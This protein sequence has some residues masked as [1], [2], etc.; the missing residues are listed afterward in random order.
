MA[1]VYEH[2]H[3]VAVAV[4]NAIMTHITPI[5]LAVCG[6]LTFFGVPLEMGP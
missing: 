1:S 3:Q 6:I 4:D 2:N 5:I